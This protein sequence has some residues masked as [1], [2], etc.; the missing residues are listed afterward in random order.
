MADPKDVIDNAGKWFSKLGGSIRQTTKQVTGLGRGSVKLELDH[1]RAAPGATLRGRVVLALSEPVEAKQ[2]IVSLRAR[3][4][5]MNIRRSNAG[6]IASTSH[7]NVYEH[8][9]E[10]AGA[11]H[12][13]SATLPFE[14]TVPPDALDLRPS[15][16]IDPVADAVR[17][18][19]SVLSPSAGPIEWEV[20][21]RLVI[22]WGRDLSDHVDVVVTT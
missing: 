4:R 7:A 5:V 3:Q 8:D 19:A 22:P 15:S 14:L 11:R 16:G 2:L 13:E 6:R 12:Y 20:I 9:H 21:A 18:V 17:T 10:L 1:T